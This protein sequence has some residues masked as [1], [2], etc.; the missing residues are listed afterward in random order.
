MPFTVTMPKLSPTMESGSIVCWHKHEN[1]YVEAGELLVEVATDKATVEYNA[2][3]GGWLRKILV[4]EGK[5]AEVNEAIA[6]FSAEKEE[7]IEGYKP[8]GT[9]KAAKEPEK[10]EKEK[11]EKEAGAPARA[12]APSSQG[13][14]EPAF[15]PEEPLSDSRFPY[16]FEINERVKASPLARKLA[17]EKGLDLTALQG[18]GPSG[19][20]VSGDLEK[21][22][23]SLLGRFTQKEAPRLPAGAYEE[24]PFTPMRKVIGRRLQEAKSFIPHFY[25]EQM[26]EAS[27]VVSLREQ[28]AAFDIKISVNDFVVRAVAITL[29]DYPAVNSGY[30]SVNRSIIRFKTVDISIAVSVEG[31]LITPII[32]HADYKSLGQLSA[33]IKSLAQRARGGKLD[34]EEYKGGSFT[35]SN[36]GMYGISSFQAVINPPQAAILAVGG[37]SEEPVVRHG[38]VAA[39][40]V[41]RLTLSCDHRIIDGALAAEFLR[42]LKNYLE[43][44]AILLL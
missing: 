40:K 21:A 17:K 15:V 42:S 37:I 8:E 26:V 39:G 24:E 11:V 14:Y 13:L 41:L 12:A 34:L 4:A 5:E 43:N 16:S 19:R 33:E 6:I 9:V 23:Q 29:R 18:S 25:V 31:G 32:R 10:P 38:L 3:D 27:A 30:N 20:I 2:L 36:L 44:P 28:L 35:V 7:S 1:E 22:P